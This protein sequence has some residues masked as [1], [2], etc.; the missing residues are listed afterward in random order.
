MWV[1]QKTLQHPVNIKNMDLKMAK[2]LIT[3]FGGPNGELAASLRYLSQRYTMPTGKTRALLTDI[4]TEELAHVEMI[5]SMVYQL[6]ADATPEQLKAAGLGTNYAQNGFGIYPSDANGVPF[7]TAYI[8]VM[9]DP[10]TDLHEDM[11]AEQKARV[12][13][14]W[15]INL[16]DDQD[17]KEILRFLRQREVVHFQRFCEELMDV[18]DNSKDKYDKKQGVCL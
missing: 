9:G 16:T 18:K 15:L 11:A 3:Q 2:Y 17:I 1:Y 12:T 10:V 6:T 8:A 13:Y 4:G 14:E 7:T 5:A